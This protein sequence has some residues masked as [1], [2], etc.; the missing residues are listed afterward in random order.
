[1]LYWLVQG[2]VCFCGKW[3]NQYSTIWKSC[4][5]EAQNFLPKI[6]IITVSRLAGM[7]SGRK[8]S[9]FKKI[10][11]PLELD[12]L[13]ITV[14]CPVQSG[15]GQQSSALQETKPEF[16]SG[17]TRFM[18]DPKPMNHKQSVQKIKIHAA[19]KAEIICRENYRMHE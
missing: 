11:H 18:P 8:G 4:M 16:I 14:Y 1:S 6:G 7:V 19:L 12:M 3:D 15:L 2:H 17:V 9:R 5:S 10:A 13:E